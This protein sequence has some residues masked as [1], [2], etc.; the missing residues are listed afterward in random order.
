M[1]KPAF[2]V[3]CFA[4]LAQYVAGSPVP[5]PTADLVASDAILTRTPNLSPPYRAVSVESAASTASSDAVCPGGAC[6]TFVCDAACPGG[7]CGTF[8]CDKIH[9]GDTSMQ[10]ASDAILTRTP[11]LSPTHLAVPV[12]SVAPRARACPGGACG[13]FTASSDAACPGGACSTFTASDAILTRTPNLN[14]THLAVPVE[15]VAP[16]ASSG[17]V[18]PGGACGTFTTSDA[19]LTRT[20]NLNPTHLAVPVES[21]AP[22]ASSGAVCPGGACGT[23][24]ASD[25]IL[26]RTPNLRPTHLAVPVESAAPVAS[27][28]ACPGGA[29][30][31][32]HLQSLIFEYVLEPGYEIQSYSAT[33]TAYVPT[34]VLTFKF[35]R[36]FSNILDTK[37]CQSMVSTVQASITHT[38]YRSSPTFGQ[39]TVSFNLRRDATVPI[40]FKLKTP[41]LMRASGCALDGRTVNPMSEPVPADIHTAHEM[42]HGS[43]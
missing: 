5:S 25:A 38:H 19:I 23:F 3:F 17:A 1:F 11:N 13:T 42:P 16:S 6:G 33:P 28:N 36:I 40:N 31:T 26:T 35:L 29:C 12:E 27:S 43:A 41:R 14:P 4:A 8:G 30:G 7:A 2:Y 20:P 10:T 21:V 39:V 18:C 34:S 37:I 15:S 22:S 32:R 24:T 9:R